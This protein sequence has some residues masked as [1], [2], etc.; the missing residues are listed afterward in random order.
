MYCGKL[1]RG[2]VTLAFFALSVLL[3][4]V[5]FRESDALGEE[6][7][8][9]GLFAVLVLYIFS[10]LDAYY[11]A[12]ET[13]A[14]IDALVDTNNP[15]VAT[16]LNL[17]TNG[18]GYWYLGERTK[19][20][21]A[22][23]VLGLLMRGVSRAV[24]DSPWSLLLLLIPCVMAL[25]AYRIAR[26]QLAEQREVTPLAAKVGQSIRETRLP[27]FVPLGFA[28]LLIFLLAGLMVAG[29]AIPRLDQIDQSRAVVDQNS[30]PRRYE[31]PTYGMRL[32]IPNTWD[33]D[34]LDKESLVTV[35]KD[36]ACQITLLAYGASPFR[37]LISVRE[38]LTREVL[39]TYPNFRKVADRST[40]LGNLNGLETEFV[41]DL[42][43]NVVA[44]RYL[45][46]R[47]HLVGYSFITSMASV[48]QDECEPDVNWI[49]E[50]ISIS[51]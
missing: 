34:P 9:I 43:G 30:D 36:G 31:N 35:R 14:G 8:G 47:R 11:V 3:A 50:N 37:R 16:T 20:W 45:I 25:D 4:V 32:L 10:F 44:Q 5:G 28:A 2:G 42:D 49:R 24:G 41:A 29:S 27:S 23:V 12:R 40:S 26:R 39:K 17:L 22:F 15:R 19:G 48:L 46:A 13:N 33:I 51:K 1:A 7:L 6:I 18:F 21:I 38:S